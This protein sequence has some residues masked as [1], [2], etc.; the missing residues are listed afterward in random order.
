MHHFLINLVKRWYLTKENNTLSVEGW[1]LVPCWCVSRD[2][3]LLDLSL[4][5]SQRVCEIQS[6]GGSF[7]RNNMWNKPFKP[8]LLKQVSRPPGEKASVEKETCELSLSP[9][10]A[11]KRRLIHIVDDDDPLP[12]RTTPAIPSTFNA[13]RKPLIN[14]LNPIAAAQATSPVIDGHEGFYLVLW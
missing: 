13:P 6:C 9:R 5:V 7:S 8:P 2:L 14:V 4:R 1:R 12:S 3:A 11:K 10:P